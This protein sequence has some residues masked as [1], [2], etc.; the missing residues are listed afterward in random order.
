MT[1][2]ATDSFDGYSTG[3]LAGKNGGS[4]WGG[5]WVNSA[6]NVINVSTGAAYDGANSAAVIANGGNTFYTRLLSATANSGVMYFAMRASGSV[7]GNQVLTL[8]SSIGFRVGVQMT[9]TNILLLGGGTTRTVVSG[10]STN[11]WY[12]IRLT[13]D[14][15][16]NATIAYNTGGGWSSESL[17]VGFSNSGNID[18]VG[19]GGDTANVT[20]YTDYISDTDPFGGAATNAAA[21]RLVFFGI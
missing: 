13:Y 7:G 4:G 19:L 9:S 2:V 17:T 5:A 8:R 11:T 12:V 15:S 10:Y 6:V 1:W 20:Y 16:T 14:T 18:R 21:R 3:N